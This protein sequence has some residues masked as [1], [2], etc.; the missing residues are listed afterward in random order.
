VESGSV[1]HSLLT[2]GSR[3]RRDTVVV[4]SSVYDR[5]SSCRSVRQVTIESILGFRIQVW[6]NLFYDYGYEPNP[7]PARVP[8][9]P[10][11]LVLRAD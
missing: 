10:S 1:D 9:H 6:A 8:R 7:L 3:K 2:L 5:R 4:A 11:E